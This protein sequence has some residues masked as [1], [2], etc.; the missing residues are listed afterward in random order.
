MARRYFL[1]DFKIHGVNLRVEF[2]NTQ[3]KTFHGVEFL[4][5]YDWPACNDIVATE[6]RIFYTDEHNKIR[7]LQKNSTYPRFICP[8]KFISN[9]DQDYEFC[10]FITT[11]E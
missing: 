3:S 1:K 5:E 9:P 6:N 4:G 10:E 8:S 11:V 7:Y 2:E